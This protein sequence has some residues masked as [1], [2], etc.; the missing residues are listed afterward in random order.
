M[1]KRKCVKWAG[2]GEEECRLLSTYY[3]P[4]D[5]LILFLFNP[6]NNPLR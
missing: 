3:E 2:N 5:V 6:P 1:F 4:S